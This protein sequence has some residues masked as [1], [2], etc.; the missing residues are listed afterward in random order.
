MPTLDHAEIEPEA[1]AG[2]ACPAKPARRRRLSQRPAR[3]VHT[4]CASGRIPQ[5]ASPPALERGCRVGHLYLGAAR[6]AGGQAAEQQGNQQASSS[7]AMAAAAATA[8]VGASRA[9]RGSTPVGRVCCGRVRVA[10]A[11]APARHAAARHAKRRPFPLHPRP[12]AHWHAARASSGDGSLPIETPMPSPAPL[13]PCPVCAPRCPDTH[14]SSRPRSS[15]FSPTARRSAE[16]WTRRAP[17]VAESGRDW[18]R[19]A[20]MNGD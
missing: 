20:E 3:T 15:L 8:A 5:A 14:L 10:G 9:E 12:Q 2:R 18:P 19:L 11:A 13:P 17:R 7:F 1:S 6:P 16:R 4:S